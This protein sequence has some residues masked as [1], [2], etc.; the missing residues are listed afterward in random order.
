[1]G[2][3][4]TYYDWTGNVISDADVR[5]LDPGAV[6]ALRAKYALRYPEQADEAQDWDAAV[7]LTKAGV[8]KRGK[9]TV[10]AA[11]LLGKASES[12]VPP[13]VRIRWR[14]LDVDGSVTDSRVF[15]GP[16]LLSAVQAASAV[17]NWSVD[18]GPRTVSAYRTSSLEEAIFNAV[19]HQDYAMG[20]T[21]DVIERDRE[22]VSVRSAGS[23]GSTPP[24][25]YAVGRASPSSGRNRFLRDAM[26][27]SGVVQGRG[28]GIRGMFLSQA[29]RHFPLP[30]YHVDDS[31][32]TVTFPG[33]RYGPL[34]RIMDSCDGLGLE[35][36]VDLDRVCSGRFLPERRMK[37]LIEAGLVDTRGGV[38]CPA[39]GLA[40]SRRMTDR[41]AV[42]ELLRSGPASRSD[43]ARLLESRAAR[44]LTKEQ[45]SVKATNLLQS[46]RKEGLV[47]KSGGSTRSAAYSLPGTDGERRL[48]PR[49]STHPKA[50][51][52]HGL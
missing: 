41:E 5:S 8:L 18:L 51:P 21:I 2:G 24:E 14:S 29:Y 49:Y 36:I 1:M 40:E 39:V 34:P 17:R 27:R 35:T 15:D 37:A 20:G 32:V 19:A 11:I 48:G 7:L 26:S 16:I 12:L 46:M 6:R 45:V 10:A 23:F 43:V 42:L 38:P 50:T 3:V 33:T 44:P 13:S 22:S 28:S 4:G 47:V 9:I 52:H 31:F 30:S 25:S